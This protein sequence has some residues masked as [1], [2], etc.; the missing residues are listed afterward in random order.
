MSYQSLPILNNESGSSVDKEKK[1][2][3]NAPQL[4]NSKQVTSL[5]INRIVGTGIFTTPALIFQMCQGS[6]GISLLL[7]LIGGLTTFSGLAVYLTFGL[8][9]PKNGGELNYL[10]KVIPKPK[11]LIESIYAFAIIILGFSS[12]NCFAFGKYILYVFGVDSN[13]DLSRIIGC[14][15]ITSCVLLHI[16]LPKWAQ[17]LNVFLG[18]FKIF[19][20]VVI[21][22]CGVT[23][24]VAP[25]WITPQYTNFHNIWETTTTTNTNG[26]VPENAKISIDWYLL[27]VALLQVIYSFKGW[28]NANYVLGEIENPHKTLISA[29]SYGVGLTTV[30][31]FAIVFSYYL[32]IPKDE[33]SNTGVLICGVFFTKIF[34]Q[35]YAQSFAVKFV[36]KFL[37]LIITFSNYGNVLS[38]SYANARVN[39]EL[40]NDHVFP[41]AKF[42][43]KKSINASLWL[44]CFITCAILIIPR[45]NTNLY[46]LIINLYSYPGVILNIIIGVGLLHLTFKNI[47]QWNEIKV[48]F[49]S[50]TLLTG[51]F[52]FTNVFLTVVPLI[53]PSKK[54]LDFLQNQGYPYWVFP[55]TGISIL[56]LGAIYWA[57]A[58]K[59]FLKN[60]KKNEYQSLLVK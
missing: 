12:G 45:N 24:L 46:E 27:S 19:I 50:N 58:I 44:H 55:V 10:N 51:F 23:S 11:Y 7:W 34:E 38:V 43:A 26:S 25:S 60:F 33:I 28:E 8:K 18:G 47:D 36:S 30:L 31:Y 48:P 17:K 29:T 52:I 32:I 3:D 21:V 53:P 35:Y 5:I 1:N 54:S 16:Y 39:K 20:L 49:T 6:I 40:A 59:P 13:D 2:E 15:V 14:G 57:L 37:P 9:I 56:L 42:F 22:L 4:L 41:F